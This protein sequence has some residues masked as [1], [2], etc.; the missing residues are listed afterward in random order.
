MGHWVIVEKYENAETYRVCDS[1]PAANKRATSSQFKVIDYSNKT[2]ERRNKK[3][4]LP[5][6]HCFKLGGRIRT[7]SRTVVK[8]QAQ[9]W[10]N[11]T[12]ISSEILHDL[13]RN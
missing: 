1:A 12:N 9:E 11:D 10:F 2:A 7:Q 4:R 8:C 5:P 6:F 3:D 13:P